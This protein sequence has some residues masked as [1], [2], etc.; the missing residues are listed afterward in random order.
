[1]GLE[2]TSMTNKQLLR[3]VLAGFLAVV[4]FSF[5]PALHSQSAHA[6]SPN[7]RSHFATTLERE[8]RAQGT[9][10]RIQLDGDAL[11][12]LRVDWPA[13]HRSDIYRFVTSPAAQQAVRK[14]FSKVVFSNGSRR[15]EYDLTRE[16]MIS[17]PETL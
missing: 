2:F 12:T 9:D 15:W 10:V 8:M 3:T 13:V 17:S 7:V 6:V 1:L 4:F 16:S 5:T 14:G 11:D